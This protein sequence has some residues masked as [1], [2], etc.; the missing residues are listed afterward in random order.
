MTDENNS[1]QE[2][3]K[4]ARKGNGILFASHRE[5][6]RLP[7]Y[8]HE[9]ERVISLVTGSPKYV[10]G[11]DSGSSA[12]SKG[13][14]IAVATNERVLFIRDGWVFRNVQ[15]LPYETISSV[16]FTTGVLFG[17]LSI[18]GKGDG[19]FYNWVGRFA[20]SKFAKIVRQQV[21]DQNTNNWGTKTGKNPV[22][23]PTGINAPLG[24]SNHPA[25]DAMKDIVASEL[26]QL[27]ALLEEGLITEEEYQSKRTELITKL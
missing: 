10:P 25:Q 8:L 19:V 16:E 14:G 4:E 7:S 6:R 12:S 17:T 22:V 24:V 15:D 2:Q 5:M 11:S 1:W 27:K 13:R 20:G 18:F 23:V 26:R 9:G 3:I 21:S